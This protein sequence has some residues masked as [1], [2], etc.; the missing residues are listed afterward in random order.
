MTNRLGQSIHQWG[1]Q[2]LWKTNFKKLEGYGQT[3]HIT[4]NSFKACRPHILLNPFL[5]ILSQLLTNKFESSLLRDFKSPK[6][7][8]NFKLRFFPFSRGTS[9]KEIHRLLRNIK[10]WKCNTEGVTTQQN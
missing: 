3:N 4:S 7:T 8:C 2:K 10:P 5:N 1:K 9:K 6:I